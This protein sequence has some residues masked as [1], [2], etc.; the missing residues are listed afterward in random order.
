MS[1]FLPPRAAAVFALM[2]AASIS[3]SGCQN[4]A[5]GLEMLDVEGVWSRATAEAGVTGVIYATITNRG[6]ESDTLMTIDAD[7]AA[8]VEIHDTRIE[9]G[10]MRMKPV[11]E[12]VIP[13]HETVR[14]EPGGLH[15]M[16]FGTTRGL[17]RGTT[18]EVRFEF[19]RRGAAAVSAV[20]R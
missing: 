4:E 19:R 18:F 15:G 13:P 1:S 5:E 2:L 12:L 6:N 8:T 11:P 7:V 20:V 17:E 9:D 3:V 14:L 16:M 10:V